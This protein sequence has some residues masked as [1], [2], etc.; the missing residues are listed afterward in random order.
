MSVSTD[1]LLL[2]AFRLWTERPHGPFFFD[3]DEAC[4]FHLIRK[5]GTG[6][7]INTRQ[8][9]SF[10]DTVVP[11]VIGRLGSRECVIGAA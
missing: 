9:S 5:R 4:V 11:H 6:A 1:V 7:R 2:S 8:T 10:H 3:V